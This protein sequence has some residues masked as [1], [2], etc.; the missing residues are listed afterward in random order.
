MK[1]K[2]K[3]VYELIDSRNNKVF[4]VGQGTYKDR[5]YQ[6]INCALGKSTFRYNKEREDMYSYIR[7]IYN[8]SGKVKVIFVK[9]NLEYK[10]ACELEENL[11]R[12]LGTRHDGNGYL[13]NYKYGNKYPKDYMRDERNHQYGT[14]HSSEHLYKLRNPRASK[15]KLS[16]ETKV[17][18]SKNHKGPTRVLVE[19]IN[20]KE[21]EEFSTIKEC[22][23]ELQSRYPDKAFSISNVNKHSKLEDVINNM[24]IIRRV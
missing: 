20:T 14:L 2:L 8:S 6:T 13:F 18:M 15:W 19:D 24:F 22:A 11:T 9:E 21:V 23:Q 1:R 16:D 4:Y 10:D 3:F 5:P 17:K 12:E 7:D